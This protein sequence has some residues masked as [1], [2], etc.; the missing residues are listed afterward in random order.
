MPFDVS[1][2]SLLIGA[3]VLAASRPLLAAEGP[4]QDKLRDL[5]SSVGGRLG[6][7]AL[8]METDRRIDYRSLAL[9]PLGS[10][11]KFLLAGA[12]LAKVDAGK[13]TLDREIA[14]SQA[15]ML[16]NS[17]EAKVLL[18]KGKMTVAEACA[19]LVIDNDN[20]AANLL[21]TSIGGPGA[22][23]LYARSLGDRHTHV[24]RVEPYLN[25]ATPG[26]ARDTT[27]PSAMLNDMGVLLLQDALS[28][29]S[30]DILLDW[31]VK[32][33]TGSAKL[34]AGFPRD[35]KVGEKSGRGA[36]GTNN[37]IAIAWPPGRKPVLISAYLTESTAGLDERNKVLADL[38]R[39]IVTDLVSAS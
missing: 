34:R 7:A 30:R 10:S 31:M 1:R 29:G 17:P 25:E 23:T 9:F 26:D 3:S 22:L 35:W 19:G 27:A 15:D 21:M 8:D 28:K 37:D 13:E 11:Y 6:V 14:L 32:S 38:A 16:E 5:E 36:H 24:D 2:R 12:V 20:T 33:H 4:V 18:P 39:L